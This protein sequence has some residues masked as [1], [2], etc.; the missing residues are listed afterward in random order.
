M[1]KFTVTG[2][3]TYVNSLMTKDTI[4]RDVILEAEIKDYIIH[5]SGHHYMT[6]VDDTSSISAV[7]YSNSA[8]SL[9]FKAENGMS[10]YVRGKVSIYS[11]TGRYQFIVNQMLLKG[12]GSNSL[13]YEQLKKKL[14]DEGL[15]DD[16]HKKPLPKMPKCV[17]VVTSDSGDAIKDICKILKKRCPMAELI[18]YP[19]H[20]QGETAAY[21]M[22]K[23]VKKL[24]AVEKIDV[25]IIGRG[26][27]SENDLA[28]FNDE[29]LV[30]T[31]YKCEKPIVSGIGHE[32]DVTLCDFVVDKR[33]STPSDAAALVSPEEGE[34]QKNISGLKFKMDLC[35]KNIISVN[36][37]K[38]NSI[39][40]SI[41]IKDP[42][43]I[44]NNRKSELNILDAKL[45]NTMQKKLSAQMSAF[46]LLNEKLD[47]LSPLKVL[48]RGYTM[49]E[50]KG[51]LISSVEVVQPED[52]INIRFFDG[53]AECKVI[54]TVKG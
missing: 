52:I 1:G 31:I 15:F 50:K 46:K 25:M 8:E 39:R 22:T 34:L 16:A 19:V 48:S 30:R 45:D 12:T 3:N 21:E 35:I 40:S 23:A 10:V 26:G 14:S 44:V 29:T 4:L 7:M 32:P 13:A 18:V 5:R 24:D 41:M 49:A 43:R 53:N 27:G 11:K 2:L 9:S 54:I 28:P 33:G 38:L 36:N 47:A 17:G 6:L 37:N 42:Q 20:V 51:S